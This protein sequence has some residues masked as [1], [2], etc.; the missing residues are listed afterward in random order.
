MAAISEWMLQPH[1]ESTKKKMAV[2]LIELHMEFSNKS[3]E[4]RLRFKKLARE[5]DLQTLT[6]KQIEQLH[7]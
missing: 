4:K 6:L 5:L 2:I 7:S 1:K 3:T